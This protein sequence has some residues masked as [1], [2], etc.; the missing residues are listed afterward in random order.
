MCVG[1]LGESHIGHVRGGDMGLVVRSHD[2]DVMCLNGENIIPQ[3]PRKGL[4][5]SRIWKKGNNTSWIPFGL[6]AGKDV[7]SQI[8]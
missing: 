4:Y 2:K 7:I 1:T 5:I 3:E 6:N 8:F